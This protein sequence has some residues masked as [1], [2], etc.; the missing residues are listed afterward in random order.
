MKQ[1]KCITTKLIKFH[2]INIIFLFFI[3]SNLSYAS[4][5]SIS[6]YS[7]NTPYNLSPPLNIQNPVITARDITDFPAVGVADPFLFCEN[8]IWYLFFEIVEPQLNET[9]IGLATSNDG[10]NWA[11]QQVVLDESFHLAYPYV[12]KW[13]NNYYMIPDTYSTSSVRLYKATN[14]PYQWAF[15]SNLITGLQY[16][17]ASIVYYN[18]R[19]WLFTSVP[20]NDTLYLF[21]ADTLTG[22]WV[23]HAL[24]SII[25]GNSDNARPGG[26]IVNYNGTLLR[27]AQDD[28]PTYGNAVHVF[29]ITN[30]TTSSYSKREIPGSPFLKASGMGWNSKG[31]HNVDPVQVSSDTWIACVDG[32]GEPYY[33]TITALVPS[34]VTAGSPG[35][36]LQISGNNFVP[37]SVVRWEGA[38]RATTFVSATQLTASIT[39]A[40]LVTPGTI[41]VTVFNPD[42]SLSN[43]ITFEVQAPQPAVTGLSPSS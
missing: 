12:F 9:V 33:I 21:Y 11:Y 15:V 13:Q 30:L 29:E 37:G 22:P 24:N 20:S 16:L 34:F 4:E 8:S 43:A 7:G 27:H 40:D 32:F 17:D 3:V 10:M 1:I 26:R 2:L 25:R 14:F 18:N 6:I 42:G 28:N 41:P 38:N 19:W 39:S 5:W 36:V 35:F 23:N 31:M